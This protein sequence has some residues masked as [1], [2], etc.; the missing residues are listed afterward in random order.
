MAAS[1][2]E[3]A[4]GVCCRPPASPRSS[5]RQR[6]DR[7]VSD[8]PKWPL[9]LPSLRPRTWSLT[10]PLKGCW[11]PVSAPVSPL[12]AAENSTRD[13]RENLMDFSAAL[14]T[15][16]PAFG[17]ER[18]TPRGEPRQRAVVGAK[19][20]ALNVVQS[21]PTVVNQCP[22]GVSRSRIRH[23][24]S[25][26]RAETQKRSSGRRFVPSADSA[27]AA[28]AGSGGVSN[29]PVWTGCRPRP[30]PGGLLTPRCPRRNARG[31]SL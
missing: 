26:F 25:D 24:A 11:R 31:F 13:L 17:L 5:P 7:G 20:G 29:P 8:H 21:R 10:P 2:P 18:L 9:G 30:R 15:V 22:R 14:F 4:V 23:G 3:D 16:V 19:S 12:E 1:R 6:V 28:R 27:L